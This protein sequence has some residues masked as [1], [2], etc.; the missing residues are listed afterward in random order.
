[1]TPEQTERELYDRYLE[2][3]PVD[4]DVPLSLTEWRKEEHR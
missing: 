3:D 1:M 4:A 2:E